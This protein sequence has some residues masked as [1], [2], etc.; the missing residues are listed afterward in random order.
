LGGRPQP[1]PADRHCLHAPLD[2]PWVTARPV[3]SF[4]DQRSPKRSYMSLLLWVG[5]RVGRCMH[6]RGRGRGLRVRGQLGIKIQPAW[7]RGGRPGRG[8]KSATGCQRG[9]GGGRASGRRRSRKWSVGH[10][11]GADRPGTA[12][13]RSPAT[14]ADAEGHRPRAGQA[15]L[16]PTASSGARL[17]LCNG[18][19]G[20]AAPS[21]RGVGKAARAPRRLPG[22]G[23][24][25]RVVGL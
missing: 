3:F 13:A 20:E 4:S 24:R 22:A 19:R 18:A 21:T 6:G 8:H 1:R 10:G 15:G 25:R 16:A 11:A 14:A 9:L 17:K 7:E 5:L 2:M 12:T 23:R